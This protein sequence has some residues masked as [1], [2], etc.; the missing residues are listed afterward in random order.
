MAAFDDAQDSSLYFVYT[1]PS[2]FYASS[3]HQN[4]YLDWSGE[5]DFD[6]QTTASG[7]SFALNLDDTEVTFYNEDPQTD[8]MVRLT[9]ATDYLIFGNIF[10]DNEVFTSNSIDYTSDG[11]TEY[12]IELV[13]VVPDYYIDNPAYD[14]DMYAECGSLVMAFADE[15]T[16]PTSEIGPLYTDIYFNTNELGSSTV[17][18]LEVTDFDA[19]VMYVTPPVVIPLNY[20]VVVTFT[21]PIS[22]GVYSSITGVQTYG[23]SSFG[24]IVNDSADEFTLTL[25]TEGSCGFTITIVTGSAV[26][27]SL[28]STIEFTLEVYDPEDN[29]IDL[30]TR[31]SVALGVNPVE[32]TVSLTPDSMRYIDN[33]AT[34][35]L[36]YTITTAMY[37]QIGWEMTVTLTTITSV[38]SCSVSGDSPASCAASGTTFTLT[39]TEDATV[40]SFTVTLELTTGSTVD[41]EIQISSVTYVDDAGRNWENYLTSFDSSTFLTTL[42]LNPCTSNFSILDSDYSASDI[43]QYVQTINGFY[44]SL[45]TEMFLYPGW[46]AEFELP[47]SFEIIDTTTC[48][49]YS[50]T[51][52]TTHIAYTCDITS[53]SIWI[54]NTS[55]ANNT[56]LCNTYFLVDDFFYSPTSFAATELTAT[57]YNEFDEEATLLETT[58]STETITMELLSTDFA[59]TLNR[60]GDNV[61]YFSVADVP[62]VSD[63]NDTLTLVNDATQIDFS[64]CD[65]CFCTSDSGSSL[66]CAISTDVVCTVDTGVTVSSG[67]LVSIWVEDCIDFQEPEWT[68]QDV[69]LVNDDDTT[70][71]DITYLLEDRYYTIYDG[72][73]YGSGDGSSAND[74]TLFFYS[75]ADD[76]GFTIATYA[77]EFTYSYSSRSTSAYTS[78]TGKTLS[79]EGTSCTATLTEGTEDGTIDSIASNGTSCTNL[80]SGML[81]IDVS[82]GIDDNAIPTLTLSEGKAYY[83]GS[84]FYNDVH[85]LDCWI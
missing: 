56:I 63:W 82:V 71:L 62:I 10:S 38:D 78:L 67:D 85:L 32:E 25:D 72:Y 53:G 12:S 2:N 15:F 48:E 54:E 37:M 20:Y 58:T 70:L 31:D 74:Q 59:M 19:L 40:D 57:V 3:A 28:L 6:W 18:L 73:Y 46:Y 61:G 49:V 44:A 47:S 65:R 26:D 11:Q 75:E 69:Q 51:S 55:S 1:F 14:T 52:G 33:S 41:E 29:L 76:A 30:Y 64:G 8:E 13:D 23:G 22:V 21:T 68:T 17:V 77:L 35:E 16:T 27:L 36:D 4:L 45:Q 50:D 66:S 79:I 7:S 60:V 83:D 24:T 34:T 81:Q 42:D 5:D 80:A 39:F 43:S 84:S 9:T